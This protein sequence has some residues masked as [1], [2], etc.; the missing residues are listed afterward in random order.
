MQPFAAKI[1]KNQNRY[2]LVPVSDIK[3]NRKYFQF[4]LEEDNN[5]TQ[6]KIFWQ[7]FFTNG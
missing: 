2:A 1:M 7:F 5:S 6:K 3:K 4:L